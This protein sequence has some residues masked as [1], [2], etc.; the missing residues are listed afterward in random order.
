VAEQGDDPRGG[1]QSDEYRHADPRSIVEEGETAMSG[2][3][4]TPQEEDLT[5]DERREASEERRRRLV[6][7]PHGPDSDT[8]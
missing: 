6:D 8:E 3:A 5:I 4:G 2:P 1:L 7:T